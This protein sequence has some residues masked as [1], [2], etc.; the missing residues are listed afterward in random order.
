MSTKKT[1]QRSEHKINA[2]SDSLGEVGISSK[3]LPEA[4]EDEG[5]DE[6][7]EVSSHRVA[8]LGRKNP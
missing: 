5:L 7:V 3:L 4:D 6:P 1:S 8:L 2:V